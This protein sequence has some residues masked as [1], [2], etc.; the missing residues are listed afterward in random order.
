MCEHNLKTHCPFCLDFR[1]CQHGHDRS[2]S[3]CPKCSGMDEYGPSLYGDDVGNVSRE[4]VE[5]HG[6][7]FWYIEARFFLRAFL[8]EL[9]RN[10][11]KEK[12]RKSCRGMCSLSKKEGD[13]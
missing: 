5:S 7:W 3:P 4:D 13:R 9:K 12:A 6:A 1:E 8:E 11:E 2:K 10:H